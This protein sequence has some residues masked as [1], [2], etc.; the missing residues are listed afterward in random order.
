[1]T[2]SEFN[3]KECA[4]SQLAFEESPA[5]LV[6]TQNRQILRCNK[7]FAE[8]FGYEIEALEGEPL[9]KLYPS[10]ADYYSIGQRCINALQ[11]QS[12]YEDE[13]FMQHG[14][15][16]IFWARARGITLTPDE[17][18]KLMVWSFERIRHRDEQ[19]VKLTPRE[20]EV[21][22]YIANGLTSK[23]TAEVLGISD[24]TVEVHR[25][26]I[27]KKLGAK[28]TDDLVSKIVTIRYK[29]EYKVS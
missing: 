8:L 2:I 27:M 22:S 19:T 12:D 3:F 16:T 23:E 29:D 21:A 5:P 28:S 24:R 25:S 6:V 4:I 1:M 14:D 9:I 17:P 20:Q 7:A 11:N 18:F 15:G 13:R 26:R 10:R